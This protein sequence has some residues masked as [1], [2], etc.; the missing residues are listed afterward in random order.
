MRI[1]FNI[2]NMYSNNRLYIAIFLIV[3][4]V[5]VNNSNLI[6]FLSSLTL[7]LYFEFDWSEGLPLT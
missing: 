7:F 4:Y 5:L 3:N 1:K 6:T 2:K